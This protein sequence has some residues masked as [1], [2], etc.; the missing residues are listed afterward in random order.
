M[1]L[2]F[3]VPDTIVPT[4]VILPCTAAGNVEL[5]LGAPTPSVINTPL[6]AAATFNIARP[7]AVISVSAQVFTPVV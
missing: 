6:F 4:L 2:P 1:T 5:I 3:H 7:K